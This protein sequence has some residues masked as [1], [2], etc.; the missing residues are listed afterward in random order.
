MRKHRS[1]SVAFKRQVAEEYLA[2]ETLHALAS[3]KHPARTA[4]RWRE[5]CP[6]FAGWF[7]GRLGGQG[8]G[9]PVFLPV[10]GHQFVEPLCRVIGN[11]GE[12]VG[13]PGLRIDVTQSTCRD[14]RKHHRG[15]LAAAIGAGEEP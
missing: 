3:R 5:S 9:G 6:V 15:A 8:F 13:E 4:V 10:P 7:V 2:G 12:D 11:A 1:H 14:E